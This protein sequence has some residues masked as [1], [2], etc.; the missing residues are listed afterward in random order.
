MVKNMAT[1]HDHKTWPQNMD[2]YCLKPNCELLD[3]LI[4]CV[5]MKRQM[6]NDYGAKHWEQ[7]NKPLFKWQGHIFCTAA[8]VVFN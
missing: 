3:S 1:K 5:K 7:K 2:S 8:I 4:S 6:M